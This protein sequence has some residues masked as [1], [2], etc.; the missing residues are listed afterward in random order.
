MVMHVDLGFETIGNATLICHDR[1][2]VLATD[3]WI[4]GPAYFGSWTHSHIVPDEQREAV[5]RCRY[6]WISHGHPDHLSL[7][8]LALLTGKPSIL[9]PDHVG[10]RIAADL[11]RLDFNVVVLKDREWVELSPRLRILCIAD[12]NQDAVLLV[13]LGGT[14][15]VNIN[16]ARDHGWG[17]FVKRSI[18]AYRETF[19]LKLFGYGDADMLNFVDED[20]RRIEPARERLQ[21]GR[22]IQDYAE[23]AGVKY[24]IPFSSLHRY[25]RAD[26]IWVNQYSTRPGDYQIGFDS[27]RVTLFPPFVRF[28]CLNRR[29]EQIGPPESPDV[30]IEPATFGDDWNETLENS[31][32][33]ALYDYIRSVEHLERVVDFIAFR[34]GACEHRIELVARGFKTGVVFE[35]PRHSLMTA[36]RQESFDDLLIG[37]FMRTCLV[38]DWPKSGLYPAVT[39][40]IA[41][42]ADNGRAKTEQE[43][44][45]YFREYRNRAPLGYLRHCLEDGLMT[46]FRRRVSARSPIF[47]AS[48]RAWQVWRRIHGTL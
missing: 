9:L 8:S 24:V 7:A 29:A 5:R 6:I 40:Y 16:D 11:Q 3:P 48:R 35:A 14:L 22:T 2:P 47:H 44:R 32:K 1:G 37:N 27:K 25:Q 34:V 23:G 19:L 39:P 10:G 30:V 36:V 45:Q 33:Q 46:T 41:K 28:D 13:D 31:E 12:Y 42:Y 21:V 43:L 4:V 15:L 26:S 18:K 38:G 17:S 20:G